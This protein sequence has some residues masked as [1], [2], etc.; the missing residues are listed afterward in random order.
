M[1]PHRTERVSEALRVELAQIIGFELA[2]PR[3]AIVDVNDV[4]MA[5]HLRHAQVLVTLAGDERAQRAAMGA[6]D[7][8]RPYLR[9]QLARRLNLR[10]I[11][12]LHFELDPAPGATERVDL[13][14][15]RAK[16]LGRSTENQP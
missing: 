1:D 3:L 13:L 12:E 4:R 7:H 16:K 5:P 14:L 2:D 6:L 10:K 8:A 15:K 9:H 11:P